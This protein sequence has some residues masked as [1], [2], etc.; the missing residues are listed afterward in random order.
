MYYAVGFDLG[1]MISVY[2]LKILHLCHCKCCQ[3]A[4]PQRIVV[5][6][7]IQMEAG[8]VPAGV[9]ECLS[10]LILYVNSLD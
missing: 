7:N 9:Y 8:A 2:M 3:E 4:R 1:S 5:C 6:E 10:V